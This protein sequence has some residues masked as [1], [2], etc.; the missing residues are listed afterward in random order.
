MRETGYFWLEVVLL[1]VAP[2]LLLQFE[3]VLNTPLYL[4]WTCCSVVAGFVI[5]R[6]NVCITGFERSMNVFYTPKW[7]EISSTLLLIA[8]CVIAF[9]Y[10]VLYLDIVPRIVRVMKP[11]RWL[12][13][14]GVAAQ[15]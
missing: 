4:Y 5:N 2:I 10:A 15:A 12:A 14:R 9:R 7:S 1:A 11:T 13:N 3:K 8:G 6:L